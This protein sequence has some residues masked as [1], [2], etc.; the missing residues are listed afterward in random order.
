MAASPKSKKDEPTP[1]GDRLADFPHPRNCEVLV[2]HDGAMG[3]LI[4]SVRSGR[5]HHAWLLGGPKGIGKATLAYRMAR[6]ILHPQASEL[7]ARETNQIPGSDDPVARQIISQSHPDFYIIRRD[8]D[9][10]KKRMPQQIGVDAIRRAKRFF[11][12]TASRDGGWRVCLVDAADEMTI[13]AANALLKTVEEPPE[14]TVFFLISHAPGRLLTTI[15]SRCRRLDLKPLNPSDISQV[16]SSLVEPD[17]VQ[18]MDR[19]A[20]LSRG[21]VAKALVL[22]QSNGIELYDTMLKALGSLP[23]L[24]TLAV[25]RLAD[26]LAQRNA[27]AMSDYAM[28]VEL[29]EDWLARLALS[30]VK[31]SGEDAG[32]REIELAARLAPPGSA[33]LW[34]QAWSEITHS[35]EQANALN[36]DR[37]QVILTSF[38]KLEETARKIA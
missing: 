19:L 14:R 10:K 26:R 38:F 27:Q 37:K 25:H 33:N 28:F 13:A 20:F 36:L 5:M 7:A 35:L 4:A 1:E 22:S 31:K 3:E 8:Y 23:A 30:A 21:S 6:L 18:S 24:D 17:S 11:A 16:I 12:N 2:G 34:T 29:F 9:E 15:R 32:A